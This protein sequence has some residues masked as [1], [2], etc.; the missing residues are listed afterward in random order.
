MGNRLFFA[1]WPTPTVREAVV[2]AQAA[3][4]WPT[5]ARPTLMER[6]HVTLLFLDPVP[7]DRLRPLLEA[8]DRTPVR[9]Q[10]DLLLDT[11]AL[12]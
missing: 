8:V 2:A 9:S 12:W 11:S 5:R 10:G 7:D 3:W 4:R 1:L 6:L